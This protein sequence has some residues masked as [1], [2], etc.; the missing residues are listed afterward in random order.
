MAP[1]MF[2]T[3]LDR[4][5][6]LQFAGKIPV[7]VHALLQRARK[8]RG[9]PGPDLTRVRRALRGITQKRA[10]VETRGRKPKLTLVKLRALNADVARVPSD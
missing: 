4:A 1:H 6:A 7:D 10:R 2:D 3:E 9:Q 5:T 8:A